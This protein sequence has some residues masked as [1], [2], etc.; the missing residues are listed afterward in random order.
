MF[1]SR[2][3]KL[4]EHCD[5]QIATK[6]INIR[7][8][9]SSQLVLASYDRLKHIDRKGYKL[10]KISDDLIEVIYDFQTRGQPVCKAILMKKR[11][12]VFIENEQTIVISD[13]LSDFKIVAEISNQ[14]QII[15][16]IKKIN[17]AYFMT[18]SLKY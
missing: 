2:I 14:G 10:L 17:E 15:N 3:E 1:E 5:S 13:V 18:I 9:L 11:F 8:V 4:A 16:K 6:Q 7:D 12:I